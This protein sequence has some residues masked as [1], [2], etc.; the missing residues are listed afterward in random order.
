MND[1]D[2]QKLHEYLL[3]IFKEYAKVCEKNNLSYFAIAGTTLGTIRHDGFIPWDDDLDVGMPIKDFIKLRDVSNNDLKEPYC[4]LDTLDKKRNYQYF[5]KIE[6]K[7]TA[8]IESKNIDFKKGIWI[9]IMPFSGVPDSNFKLYFFL[10][11]A[12]F[13]LRLDAFR[14]KKLNKCKGTVQKIEKIIS[15]PFTINKSNNYYMKKFEKLLT[16]YDFNKSKRIFYA[17]KLQ[18]SYKKTKKYTIFDSSIFKQT[19]GHKF[20]D[21]EIQIPIGYDKYL[22]QC[23]GDYM[24]IP[25]VEKRIT[26][27]PYILDFNKSYKEY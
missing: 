23:Y 14:N 25:P 8:F 5:Y 4:L 3:N 22:K 9:D 21:T 26:H 7:N 1:N 13:Y 19:I 20:E 16:K 2:L 12:H 27:K 11:K 6:N 17:W 10:K 15:L 24:R 18:F